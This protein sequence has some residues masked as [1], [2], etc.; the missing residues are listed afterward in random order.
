VIQRDRAAA[1]HSTPRKIT[2]DLAKNAWQKVLRPPRYEVQTEA[3][4]KPVQVKQRIVRRR[5]LLSP[6]GHWKRRDLLGSG[7]TTNPFSYADSNPKSGTDPTGNIMVLHVSH[8]LS[9]D[10]GCGDKHSINWGFVLDSPLGAPCD[11][12]FVQKVHAWFGSAR[13]FRGC[14]ELFRGERMKTKKFFEAWSVRKGDRG[15]WAR[16]VMGNTSPFDSTDSFLVRHRDG[17][18]GRSE[19]IGTVKFFCKEVTGDL[20]GY[21]V[22]PDVIDSL[23]SPGWGPGVVAEAGGLTSSHHQPKWWL[24]EAVESEGSASH[25]MSNKG[26]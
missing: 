17:E 3:R 22:P 4:Q 25:W 24:T 9:P 10:K 21:R 26:P 7:G 2:H 6:L 11:G 19:T 23:K 16:Y 14:D 12:Y 20:G 5:I 13:S 8:E 15:W 18:C 1:S